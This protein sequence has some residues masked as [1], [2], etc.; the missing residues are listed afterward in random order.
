MS[1]SLIF[2]QNVRL[3]ILTVLTVGMREPDSLILS[4]DLVILLAPAVLIASFTL[5][6]ASVVA[7]EVMDEPFLR[8]DVPEVRGDD[9]GRDGGHP[10]TGDGDNLAVD[11]VGS[12]VLAV[13]NTGGLGRDPDNVVRGR[14]SVERQPDSGGQ[15]EVEHR[16]RGQQGLGPALS[17]RQPSQAGGGGD[18]GLYR[19]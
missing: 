16:E 5:T 15:V 18:Q 13:E 3:I 19:K 9:L 4:R 2:L 17:I 6:A 8:L 14:A 1:R 11:D 10:Q 12:F 7:V